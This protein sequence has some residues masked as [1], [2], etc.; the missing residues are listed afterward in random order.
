VLSAL[1]VVLAF[2]GRAEAST[3]QI[4][5]L[6]QLDLTQTRT[7]GHADLQADGLHI[8][9]DDAT[10]QAKVAAYVTVDQPLA[11]VAAGAAPTLDYTATTGIE[12]GLQLVFTWSGHTA[13]LVGET[14]YG[15]KWWISDSGCGTWCAD[16]AVAWSGGGGSAH[17]ATLAEWAAAMPGAQVGSFGF[18]LGSGVHASGV[19]KSLTLAG[20]TF[21]FK[22]KPVIVVP[23]T[24]TSTTP[25]S[26]STA[27]S[28]S[29]SSTSSAPTSSSTAVQYANCDAVRAADAAP[30]LFSQPGYRPDLDSDHDGVACEQDETTAAAVPVVNQRPNSGG[31]TETAN[32]ASTGPEVSPQW[33]VIVALALMAVGA[34]GI[35]FARL[36]RRT[37]KDQ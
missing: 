20:V 1:C 14:V 2:A 35:L 21:K 31:Y 25:P 29:T 22:L 17:S 6:A 24:S 9:T 8:W 19:V 36:R 7:A 30:L 37:G 27:P 10:S 4:G 33:V 13:I 5:A 18:S 16:L 26:S 15:G 11:S 32:L 23:P 12:P 28:S 34:S 3:T